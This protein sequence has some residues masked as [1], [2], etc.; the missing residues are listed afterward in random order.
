[1]KK[2]ASTFSLLCIFCLL[3]AVSGTA[4]TAK[5]KRPAED[6]PEVHF[7]PEGGFFEEE[8]LL[9]LQCPN[10][11]I[12][13]TT[14]GSTPGP[15]K[16]RKYTGALKISKTTVVRTVAVRQGQKG[17]PQAHTYFIREPETH[18]LT[19]SLAIPPKL[20]FDPVKGL[21]V[22]GPKAIDSIRALPGAN[23]WSRREFPIQVEFFEP[24]GKCVFRSRTGFRLFGGMSRLFPQKS[25]TLVTRKRYGAKRFNYPVFGKDQPK[26][27]KFLV[28]RNSGSECGRT[29]FRDAFQT[30]LL[31]DWDLD[32]QAWRPAHVYI[33]G[34]YWGI[35]NI[36]EKINRYFIAQHHE[37]D[38]DSIDL[39]EHRYSLR[40]GTKKHY[41]KLLEFL[42]THDLSNPANYAYVQTQM[43]VENFMLYQIAQIY[44]DN[45]DAGGNIKFWRPRRPDGRWRWVLYDTDW[46]F[47]LYDKT[48]WKNNSLAFHTEAHGPVWPNPPWSTFILR[49]L[50]E[51]ET[52]RLA[53]A[54]RFADELNTTFEPQRVLRQLDFFVQLYEPEMPRQWKR[55]KYKPEVWYQHIKR[56]RTFAERRPQ[57]LRQYLS[58]FFELGQTA[59]WSM[60][61]SPGGLVKLNDHILLEDTTFRA[62]Y[63]RNMPLQLSAEPQL[64]HRFLYW[65]VN[66]EQIKSREINILPS[67]KINSLRAVFQPYHHPLEDVLIINEISC[68]NKDAGDWIELYNRSN[69]TILLNNWKLE[70]SK[71][72][73]NI[74]KISIGAKEY[75]VLCQNAKKFKQAFPESY[76]FTGDFTF[77][78]NKRKEHIA[79]Y[80]PDGAVID[81][82]DY[83]LPPL[84]TVFSLDLMLPSLNNGDPQNWEMRPGPGSPN[85]AN[86]YYVESSLRAQR[87][88]WIQIGS[89]A[90]LLILGI[91]LLILRAQKKI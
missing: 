35:Y 43:D 40:R 44:F 86:A 75:L 62:I 8:V 39:F 73:F 70:D 12:Y 78:L 61:I 36:R 81:V 15:G 85:K 25:M 19:V 57:Y 7:F 54:R 1:L 76:N 82:V 77:G 34:K 56:M 45:Q 69:Q 68:N 65:I 74:P 20:L 24:S 88:R 48:A 67:K 18:F 5:T 22:K 27:F 47:G 89:S 59:K 87:K 31:D 41:R 53:F 32:K 91:I 30:S 16:S 17:V 46:G 51:N 6:L 42:R 64:G 49:K 11:T 52:F 90:G 2:T 28:L 80:A 21:F 50:L 29:Q 71:H 23:F 60:Y 10:A 55:W 4:Q 9:S 14:D 66:G 26:K 79:L 83:E 13:Y 3:H 38:K 84:D 63:F 33:N 58:D 37:V 72:V